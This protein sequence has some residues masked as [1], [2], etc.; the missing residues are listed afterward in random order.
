M[1]EICELYARCP[2]YGYRKIGATLR[3]CGTKIN[4]KK[5][6]RLMQ[7]IGLKA[8]GKKRNLSKANKKDYKFPYLLNR[9]FKGIKKIR[10]LL[11]K[12]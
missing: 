3:N 4:N 1:N 7:Q 2:F 8:I 10:F 6:Q 11:V 12:T 5:V 9:T